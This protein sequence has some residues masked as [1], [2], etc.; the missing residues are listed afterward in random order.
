MCELACE[1]RRGLLFELGLDVGWRW[2]TP[3]HFVGDP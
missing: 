1:R 3:R 2:Q